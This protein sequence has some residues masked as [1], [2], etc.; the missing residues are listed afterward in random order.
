M[1]ETSLASTLSAAGWNDLERAVRIA[2][3]AGGGIARVDK[4]SVAVRGRR[5]QQLTTRKPRAK[6]KSN[7]GNGEAGPAAR[8]VKP[9]P[10]VDSTTRQ[11]LRSRERLQDFQQRKRMQ[12]YA[13]CSLRPVLWRAV[14]QLR[15]QRRWQLHHEW[16]LSI[17]VDGTIVDAAM[18]E[19]TQRRA[20]ESLLKLQGLF[21]EAVRRIRWMRMHRY[22]NMW[23]AYDDPWQCGRAQRGAEPVLGPLCWPRDVSTFTK[24]SSD[25]WLHMAPLVRDYV[26]PAVRKRAR[27]A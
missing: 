5:A 11:Q 24:T 19:A 4:V 18:P 3:L 12:L 17:P 20:S 13:K 25:N 6:H 15:F 26:W 2:Q 22:A 16:R 14:R 8:D 1:S 9:R 7:D 10:A 23:S 21:V 27:E